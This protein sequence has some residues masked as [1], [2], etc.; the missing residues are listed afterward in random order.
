VGSVDTFRQV[1]VP[2]SGVEGTAEVGQSEAPDY[3]SWGGSYWGGPLGWGGILSV[4]ESVTGVEASGAIGTVT[5]V[6]GRAV[7]VLSGVVAEGF[8]GD[9]T[10]RAAA[11][12]SVTGV[13]STGS[14]GDI[15]LQ[16]NNN[17]EVTGVEATAVVASVVVRN[18]NYIS[19]T[20]IAAAGSVG[21]VEV[22]AKANVVVTGVFATGRVG[23]PLVWSIIDTAQTPDWQPILEAA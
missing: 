19:T 3:Q 15:S 13:D 7:V 10:P 22:D 5:E 11:N 16:S 9:E 14:I 1:F 18:I 2:V 20:G 23:R 8:L 6:I 21:T 4:E 12:V 17:I